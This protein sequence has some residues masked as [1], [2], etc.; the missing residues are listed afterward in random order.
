[1]IEIDDDSSD[2]STV[3]STC[4]CQE[5]FMI[6]DAKGQDT[7]VYTRFNISE[8]CRNSWSFQFHCCL[9]VMISWID[10]LWIN[11]LELLGER[12]LVEI[13]VKHA[14]SCQVVRVA[15]DHFYD[16]GDGSLTFVS[17][18][19]TWPSRERFDV[20]P[21]RGYTLEMTPINKSCIS[22]ASVSVFIQ[23][24]PGDSFIQVILS[25]I[26][27]FPAVDYCNPA[28]IMISFYLN[29]RILSIWSDYLIMG[30]I[31][32]MVIENLHHSRYKCNCTDRIQRFRPELDQ[33]TLAIVGERVSLIFDRVPFEDEGHQQSDGYPQE[34]RVVGSR[35]RTGDVQHQLVPVA[36]LRLL[37]TN[38]SSFWYRLPFHRSAK[39]A[40]QP[41]H[42]RSDEDIR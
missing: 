36:M 19:S 4:A 20:K 30:Q 10:W 29:Q 2:P 11:N 37:F 31:R 23:T 3:S 5:P 33:L 6:V 28:A 13:Q 27:S 21:C 18:N 1:M 8:S 24:V 38:H 16:N 39:F 7:W 22:P 40:I 32:L 14:L 15:L 9:Y 41:I 12:L 42:A 34:Q 25:D 35:W 17:N 26:I